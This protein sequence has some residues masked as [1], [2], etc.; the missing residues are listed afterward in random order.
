MKHTNSEDTGY[1]INY[2]ITPP[3]KVNRR[4]DVSGPPI[5]ETEVE[6]KDVLDHVP[7]PTLSPNYI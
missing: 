4:D 2:N 6:K 7:R 1:C 5:T 3:H